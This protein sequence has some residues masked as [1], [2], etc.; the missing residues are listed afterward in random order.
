MWTEIGGIPLGPVNL[1]VG[2]SDGG[3]GRVFEE[4]GGGGGRIRIFSSHF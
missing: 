2:R 3:S 4:T 1:G